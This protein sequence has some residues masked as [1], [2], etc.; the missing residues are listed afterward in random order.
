MA[1]TTKKSARVRASA[2]ENAPADAVLA[3]Q[4]QN[5][6]A[7]LTEIPVVIH[8]SHRFAARGEE[9]ASEP[10]REETRTVVVFPRGAMVYLSAA[11][12]EGELVVLTNRQTRADVL[13][14]VVRT[15]EQPGAQNFV[16]LEFTLPSPKF[17]DAA[18]FAGPVA[19]TEGDNADAVKRKFPVV[20]PVAVR[21]SK[22]E[23]VAVSASTATGPFL[24][25]PWADGS[26]P[27]PSAVVAAVSERASDAD[28]AVLSQPETS[29]DGV[30]PLARVQK[31]VRDF[32]EGLRSLDSR[33]GLWATGT[34]V[35]A[36]GLVIIGFG[37][38]HRSTSTSTVAA[39][40][41]LPTA[42]LQPVAAMAV[43]PSVAESAAEP[44]AAQRAGAGASLVLPAA[45]EDGPVVAVGDKEAGH[46]QPRRKAIDVGALAAPKLRT[47]RTGVASEPP[48]LLASANSADNL[49]GTGALPVA[50]PPRG[51]TPLVPT[52]D[53][54]VR[55][56]S[57]FQAPKVV[58]STAPV[59]PTI[60]RQQGLEGVVV[61]DASID[62][63]GN[64]TDARVVSGPIM[65]RQ[66]ALEAVRQWKY[67]PAELNGQ[68]VASHATVDLNFTRQ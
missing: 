1:T 2:Q 39:V 41:A 64:V 25:R 60:A 40:A 46:A 38:S 12:F 24:V 66:A 50:A 63:I 20:G 68:P 7:I 10:L 61:L 26:I 35:L 13:C 34:C 30:S 55:P 48:P 22:A 28:V 21:S 15:T 57:G 8:A 33:R 6:D 56:G 17:W 49:L 9:S 52:A 5:P 59:Y 3:V 37:L 32:V 31:G 45:S 53:S 14:R 42:P 62:E 67:R 29:V 43:V 16:Q 36:A 18:E 19:A 47:P 44:D 58:R 27:S 54:P 23:P 11:L 51:A 4:T 65:L